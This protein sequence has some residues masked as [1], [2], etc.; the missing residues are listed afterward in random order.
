MMVAAF[1]VAPRATRGQTPK[2]TGKKQ[3]QRTRNTEILK[4][5]KKLKDSYGQNKNRDVKI[6]P[7]EIITR[8]FQKM[9]D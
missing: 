3:A 7:Y 9:K 5:I 1:N 4:N 2:V 6:I 8:L